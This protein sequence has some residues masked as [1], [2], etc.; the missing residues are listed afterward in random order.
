[1][2]RP[3]LLA[4]VLL[5]GIATAAPARAGWINEVFLG[6]ATD[7]G[8]PNAIELAGLDSHV[9]GMVDLVVIDARPGDPFG[10]VKQVI[11]VPVS[12]PVHLVSDGAW[13]TA[14]WI[15]P[16]PAV[17]LDLAPL[18]HAGPDSFHFTAATR[19]HLYDGPTNLTAGHTLHDPF[20]PF[21][22][23]GT[24]LLDALTFAPDAEAGRLHDDDTVLNTLAGWVLARPRPEDPAA[25]DDRWLVGSPNEQGNLPWY[26]PAFR[27]TP[28]RTNPPWDG[29]LMPEPA[30]L[31]VMLAGVLALAGRGRA[32]RG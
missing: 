2:S 9:G 13:P 18:V 7:S 1:M 3:L 29:Q 22:L 30:S 11:R 27:V 32:G 4:V 25:L 5:A 20:Y 26:E 12:Q 15:A 10:D 8:A 23:N 14:A 21:R 17:M 24:Q 6:A 19:L 31:A 28:G 16:D